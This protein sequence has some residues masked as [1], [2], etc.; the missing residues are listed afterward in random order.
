MHYRRRDNSA[1]DIATDRLTHTPI[2]LILEKL[3]KKNC[4]PELN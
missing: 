3:K 1:V 4:I 2:L